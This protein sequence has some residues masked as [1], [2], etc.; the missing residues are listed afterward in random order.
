MARGQYIQA[1]CHG[2]GD[3][4]RGCV[5]HGTD[6]GPLYCHLDF[7]VRRVH[8]ATCQLSA[9]AQQ[10]DHGRIHA[11]APIQ[12]LLAGQ[13]PDCDRAAAA[14]RIH[15][16]AESD[17][18]RL[19]RQDAVCVSRGTQCLVWMAEESASVVPQRDDL[20]RGAR[21]DQHSAGAAVFA[22]VQDRQA[23]VQGDV[24]RQPARHGDHAP[25]ESEHGHTAHTRSKLLVAALHQSH[26]D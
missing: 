7:A 14:E 25:V 5:R 4:N 1:H 3:H 2:T 12:L 8:T 10:G 17:P 6:Y 23:L 11:P 9:V 15:G 21:V 24:E 20:R 13:R 26:C 16:A 19:S 22:R 18:T